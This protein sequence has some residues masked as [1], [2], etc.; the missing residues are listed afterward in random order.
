MIDRYSNHNTP[1]M[2]DFSDLKTGKTKNLLCAPDPY[3]GYA[4]PDIK[5]GTIKAAD[6]ETDLYYRS[7]T[8]G[9]NRKPVRNT[10]SSYMC[11]E[12]LTSN[13]FGM[14]GSGMPE[15]GIFIWQ[16]GDILSLQ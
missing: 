6:G 14:A 5:C 3:D 13:K 16:I 15:A 10:L 1:R 7:Y 4:M 12:A 2:I 8:T 9:K 11:M